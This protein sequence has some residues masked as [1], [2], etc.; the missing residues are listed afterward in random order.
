MELISAREFARRIGV[1]L[2][3]VQKAARPENG[4]IA[5]QRDSSG[6]ITGID[7]ETQAQAWTD[8][9]KAP[10]CRPKTSAGG[11]P[12]LDGSAPAAP[13]RA[14]ADG[15]QVAS[16]QEAQGHGGS[17]KRNQKK[18]EAEVPGRKSLADIQRERELVKLQ[19]DEENLKKA[20]GEVVDRSKVYADGAKLAGQLIGALFNIPDRISDDLAGM[21]DP[22]E[23][24][25]LLTQELNQAVSK[26]RAEYGQK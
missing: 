20:R 8:N 14:N 26:L 15:S 10:Q 16:W 24:S 13:A 21:T 23:I 3:A 12:R 4:R 2:T 22:H 19:I 5:A 9:S 7:W 18:P 6:K 11:R 1:S 25:N 17:L